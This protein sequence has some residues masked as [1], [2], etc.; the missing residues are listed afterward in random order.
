LLLQPYHETG[1]HGPNYVQPPPELIDGEEEFEVECIE[2]HYYHGRKKVLQYLIKWKG[3]PS[4]NNTWEPE[5]NVQAPEVVKDYWAS[6]GSSSIKRGETFDT[7][8]CLSNLQSP[9][10]HL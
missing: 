2:Q 3:Y 9:Y 8:Q 4:S 6:Q 7:E 10:L 5:P 1:A